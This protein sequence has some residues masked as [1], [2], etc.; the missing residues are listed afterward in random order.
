MASQYADENK[1]EWRI[2]YPL[3]EGEE[4]CYALEI[5]FHPECEV[6]THIA[7]KYDDINKILTEF[8][9]N[10]NYSNNSKFLKS[11][12]SQID[13]VIIELSPGLKLPYAVENGGSDEDE[14]GRFWVNLPLGLSRG[15]RSGMGIYYLYEV[16]VRTL[17]K[18]S[19]AT[20][21]R[22]IES[23][24]S[25]VLEEN[26]IVVSRAFLE[27]LVE[28]IDQKKRL[29]Q[30]AIRRVN[31]TTTYNFFAKEL[32]IEQKPISYGRLAESKVVAHMANGDMSEEDEREIAEVLSNQMKA[33]S[34][35]VADLIPKLRMDIDFVSLEN[36]IDC[37]ATE[38]S[39]KRNEAYWQDF[40]ENNPFALQ[41]VFSSPF[42][43]IADHA[44]VGGTRIAQSGATI[45]DYLGKNTLTNN[46]IILEI[47]KPNTKLLLDMPYRA[48]VYAPS[49]E[50][51]GSIQQALDQADQLKRSITNIAYESDNHDLAA[52]A[53]TS[54][55]LIG[56]IESLNNEKA[57][58]KS[59]ELFRHS[60]N[61]VRVVTYDE[62]LE[63]LKMLRYHMQESMAAIDSEK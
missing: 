36:L 39:K 30:D 41:L 28:S 37:F 57:K 20:T 58:I 4:G 48:D 52:N 34:S 10:T 43:V 12:Y 3:I 1:H 31:E 62:V 45:A 6:K 35:T 55:V 63:H 59:F 26:E 61:A 9:F 50:L 7:G 60:Q 46:A 15:F 22:I 27:K 11:K 21:L 49:K 5:T 19:T 14:D 47:K 56:T 16:I 51:A 29:G 18:L 24:N 17:E 23:D 54:Y 8:P 40:F 42:T 33:G 44:Y 25:V 38:M 32:G 53:I 13:T 2:A